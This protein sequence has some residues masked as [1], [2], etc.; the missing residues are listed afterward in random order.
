MSRYLACNDSTR[1]CLSSGS[2]HF[3]SAHANVQR[4]QE[5]KRGSRLIEV[6]QHAVGTRE[7]VCEEAARRS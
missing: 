5:E 4:L 3:F 7:V 2:E 1:Q 6:L